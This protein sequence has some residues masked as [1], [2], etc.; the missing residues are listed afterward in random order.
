MPNQQSLLK[1]NFLGVLQPKE[2][3]AVTAAPQNE[4]TGK[5]L[6]VS[7]FSLAVDRIRPDEDQVRRF[8]KNAEDASVLELAES[9]RAVGILQPLDVRYIR[10]KNYYEIIAGE[11]R[12]TAAKLV[13]LQQ[14]PVKLLNATE[15]EVARLQIVENIHREQLSPLELGGALLRLIEQGATPDDLGKL[16]CKTKSY[17]TKALGIARNLC[18]EARQAVQNAP[19]R[20]QSMAHLYDVSLLPKEA[21]LPVLLKIADE[22]LTREQ[23]LALTTEIKAEYDKPSKGGRP[24]E[25]RLFS[26]TIILPN[27]TVTIRFRKTCATENEIAEALQNAINSLS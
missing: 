16:L 19:E 26:K 20:F 21:Q 8:N 18:T 7:L 9:I 24:T 14:V 15:E 1:E 25:K 3:P 23:L 2:S 17:V 11:R 12:Y 22:G 5:F 6:D 10:D 4:N 13:G 27:A